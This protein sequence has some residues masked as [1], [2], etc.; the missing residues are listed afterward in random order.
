MCVC[1]CTCVRVCVVVVEVGKGVNIWSN[2]FSTDKQGKYFSVGKRIMIWSFSSMS[3]FLALGYTYCR[4]VFFKI[5]QPP[6]QK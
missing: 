4:M 3:C 5:F 6:S 1:V 2:I